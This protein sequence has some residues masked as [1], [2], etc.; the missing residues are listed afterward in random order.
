M[1]EKENAV[2]SFQRKKKNRGVGLYAKLIGHIILT[3]KFPE[4]ISGDMPMHN[5]VHF[6][7]SQGKSKSI[8]EIRS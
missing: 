1:S 2:P 3:F 6:K 8:F 7:A 5:R 4:I